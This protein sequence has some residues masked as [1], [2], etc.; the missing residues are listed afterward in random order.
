[1]LY[2]LPFTSMTYCY[3]VRLLHAIFVATQ[4]EDQTQSLHLFIIYFFI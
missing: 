3:H 1:M 2:L 4:D